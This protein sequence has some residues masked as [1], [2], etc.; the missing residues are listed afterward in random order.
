MPESMQPLAAPSGGGA[1]VV[2]TGAQPRWRKPLVVGLI[3]LAGIVM[4]VASLTVWARR[5]ALN[6]DNWVEASSELLQDDAVRQAVS[7]ALVD[8]AFRQVGGDGEAGADL[9]PLL[10][11]L[12]SRLTATLRAS[13]VD[14]ADQVLARP[15]VQST[16]RDVNRVAHRNLIAVVEDDRGRDA[17]GD[18]VLDLNPLVTDIRGRLGLGPPPSPDAGR[19]VILRND[20]VE[21]LQTA[22]NAIRRVSL[23]A[24]LAVVG[25]FGAGIWLARGWRHTAVMVAGW[26]FVAVG[27]ALL[28][29]RRVAGNLVV[30]SLAGDSQN[31]AAARSTWLIATTLLRDSA[32][33]ILAIGALVVVGAWVCGASR[34]ATAVRRWLAPWFSRRPLA[35]Y[36]AFVLFALF[37]LLVLP[38]GG[39]R[40][41]G[42]ALVLLALILA[43]LEALKRMTA[44]EFPSVGGATP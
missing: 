17:S 32:Q 34:H 44:R 13:A 6:T 35:V 40:R 23:L 20:Q 12:A 21:T 26:T 7:V 33:A 10:Q 36:G 25:L 28:V 42:G 2:V 16:W 24:W 31:R 15:G 39:G 29:I 3:V 30:D 9:P 14:V 19:F 37:L 43:G 22:V 5:Q 27:L 18:V 11:P 41:H 4:L 38:V 8:A 1:Q